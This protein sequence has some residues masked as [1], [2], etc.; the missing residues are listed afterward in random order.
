MRGIEVLMKLSAL[1]RSDHAQSC[2]DLDRSAVDLER[3]EN[4]GWSSGEQVLVDLVREI[5]NGSGN[6]SVYDLTALDDDN[7]RVAIM[8]LESWLVEGQASA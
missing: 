7:R 4:F 6:G 8:A 3:L 1:S 5:Y 2:V